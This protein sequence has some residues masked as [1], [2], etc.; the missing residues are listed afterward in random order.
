MY[1]LSGGLLSLEEASMIIEYKRAI[2]GLQNKKA[3]QFS[4]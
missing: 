4:S 3:M 2:W 1:K